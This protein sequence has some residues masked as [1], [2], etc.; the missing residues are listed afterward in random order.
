MQ[1][2][3]AV[4][5]CIVTEDS[6]K[7]LTVKISGQ[8]YLPLIHV[9]LYWIYSFYGF[10]HLGA[11]SEYGPFLR[12]HA[13]HTCRNFTHFPTWRIQSQICIL[14]PKIKQF[15]SHDISA[16]NRPRSFAC[17]SLHKWNSDGMVFWHPHHTDLLH[18]MFVGWSITLARSPDQRNDSWVG[19]SQ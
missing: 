5:C 17:C 9:H 3:R 13:R 2:I 16:I 1:H 12:A 10:L 19:G 7:G 15:K 6:R 8:Q 18:V 14:C 4:E 11:L